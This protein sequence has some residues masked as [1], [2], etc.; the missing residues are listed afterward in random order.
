M[1]SSASKVS[2]TAGAA[3]AAARKYPTRA[4]PSNVTARASTP[5]APQQATSA[6]PTVKPPPQVS[7]TKTEGKHELG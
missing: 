7:E 3:G 5:S 2:K 1:G 4:P 6:G